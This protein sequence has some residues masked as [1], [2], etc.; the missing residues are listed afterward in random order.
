MTPS[1]RAQVAD[2]LIE[3]VTDSYATWKRKQLGPEPS[4]TATLLRDLVLDRGS[5][6]K[7]LK[8]T[9]RRRQ[10]SA[11]R[12]VLTSLVKKGVLETSIGLG[13]RGEARCYEP[14]TMEAGQ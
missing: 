9:T 11:I 1:D 5:C 13:E 2:L 8:Y 12:S 6:P 4:L 14:K 3:F 7:A 10:D